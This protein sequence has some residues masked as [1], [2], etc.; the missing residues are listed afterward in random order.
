MCL[1]FTDTDLLTYHMFT[2]T[3]NVRNVGSKTYTLY[4]YLSCMLERKSYILKVFNFIL[5]HKRRQKLAFQ[6][7]MNIAYMCF[8]KL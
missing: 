4:L 2:K 3:D 5:Q 8:L 6:I 7:I 1:V